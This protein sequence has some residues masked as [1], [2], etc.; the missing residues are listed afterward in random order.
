MAHVKPYGYRRDHH[1]D[2]S[3]YNHRSF[4]DKLAVA[5]SVELAKECQTVHR[6]T[7]VIFL[8]AAHQL[9]QVH[10]KLLPNPGRLGMT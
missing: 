7:V 6:Q 9:V 5:P 4:S 8:A 1:L 10:G 2:D 3:G